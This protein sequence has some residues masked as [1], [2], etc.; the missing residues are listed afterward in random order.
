MDGK[1]VVITSGLLKELQGKGIEDI[2]ELRYTDRKALVNEFTAGWGPAFQ[3]DKEILIPQINYLTNDSWEELSALDGTSG[4]P[5]LHSARYANGTLYVLTI[6]DNFT[7]LYHFPVQALTKIKEILT[8]QFDVLVEAPGQ[9]CLFLYDNNTFIVES[10]LDE[11]T[12]VIIVADKKYGRLTD[13][14]SGEILSGTAREE[15][16]F[17]G[18]MLREG[19]TTFGI[20]LK[21][22]S[23]RVF[24]CIL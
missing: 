18:M 19:K 1:D 2:A 9:V 21:P 5:I 15:L 8:G 10:F 6:P 11:T 24:R 12:P 22:H 17:R 7:D 3:A 20:D 4:W 23:Y 14:V 13:L 16:S